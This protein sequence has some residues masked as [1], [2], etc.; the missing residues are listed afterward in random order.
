MFGIQWTQVNHDQFFISLYAGLLANIVTAIIGGLIVWFIISQIDMRRLR[1]LYER[2]VAGKRTFQKEKSFLP[3]LKPSNEH[4][5][6]LW[7][8]QISCKCWFKILFANS[9]EH[10]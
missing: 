2:E 3:L 6:N 8:L 4:I 9:T 1:R 5:Q 7:W 10:S